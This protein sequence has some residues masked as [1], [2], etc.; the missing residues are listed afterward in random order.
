M[1]DTGTARNR[2]SSGKLRPM[3]KNLVI[4][5]LAILVIIGAVALYLTLRPAPAQAPVA[6]GGSTPALP[7]DNYTDHAAYYDIDAQYPAQT[8]LLAS[9]GP[10]ADK[11][12]AALMRDFI[13]TSAKQFKVDGN[14]AN[15]TPEDIKMMGFDSGRKESLQITY[16]TATGPHT[17]SYIFTVSEDTG[18]AH[19]N[20]FYKTFTF[21]SATGT[22]LGLRDLFKPNTPYLNTLTAISRDKLPDLIG[23]DAADMT[24]IN[25]GTESEEKN[26]EN[27]F[28]DDKSFVLLFPPYAVAAYSAG[29]QT[30]PISLSTLKNILKPEYQ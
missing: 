20:T 4:G 25:A 11:A 1:Q 13:D 21:D 12:A 3:S 15:L 10:K 24:F 17:V 7:V 2:Q 29:T 27:F 9:A 23:K 16:I 6:S 30:L 8:L 26:F 14:F 28:I 18:G 5:I 19:G 22:A